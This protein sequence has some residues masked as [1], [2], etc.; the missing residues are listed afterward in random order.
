MAFDL[1]TVLKQAA[2]VIDQNSTSSNYDGPRV[3]YP[4]MGTL[5]VRLL[6]SPK[7]QAVFR[8]IRRHKVDN[9]SLICAE[10]Y[11]ED[12]PLCKGIES[13]KNLT[14]S[15]M[16]TMDSK[17]LGLVLAQ[18]VEVSRDYDSG[19]VTLPDKGDIVLLMLPWSAY[20]KLNDTIQR[21]GEHADELLTRN[22]GRVVN[23][24]KKKGTS[25]IEYSVEVDAFRDSFK[26]CPNQEEFEELLNN[27]PDINSIYC[28]ATIPDDLIQKLQSEADTLLAKV[29]GAVMQAAGLTESYNTGVQIPAKVENGVVT[30]A[31]PW[32][33]VDAPQS[34]SEDCFGDFKLKNRNCLMCERA[35]Q[36]SAETKKRSAGN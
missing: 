20:T 26:S 34:N 1:T 19:N 36:C 21:S 3:L 7:S 4:G 11:H 13:Y 33:E 16:W 8:L 2:E 28:P 22:E 30:P 18:F 12:C 6:F 23:I 24:V 27:L 25:I 14:G 17:R 29:N 10:T 5:S 35:V 32:E 31:I 9:K 15:D